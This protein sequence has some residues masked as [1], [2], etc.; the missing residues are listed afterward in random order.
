MKPIF[1]LA[2]TFLLAM[3]GMYAQSLSPSV[4]ASDGGVIQVDGMTLEWTLGEAV[5]ET[6]VTPEGY[7]TQG[8][9][10]PMLRV[11]VL[12]EPVVKEEL[13]EVPSSTEALDLEIRV[14][15]N[16]VIAMLN[17]YVTSEEGHHLQYQLFD[18]NGKSLL[19]YGRLEDQPTAAIDMSELPMGIYYLRFYQKDGS[20]SKTFKISKVQ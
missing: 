19:S 13:E 20:Y 8:F 3:P 1:T 11:E 16:P 15:P 7:L 6:A 2:A 5:V 10:Q 14:A 17:V 9:H 18:Q 12:D 4:L